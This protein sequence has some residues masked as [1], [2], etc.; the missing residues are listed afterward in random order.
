M[1]VQSVCFASIVTV[2]AG[3]C[4]PPKLEAS[5]RFV[6]LRGLVGTCLALEGPGNDEGDVW[7]L[8]ATYMSVN[9]WVTT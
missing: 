2:G 3:S 6:L 4:A 5:G 1:V 9:P 7:Q 8:Q